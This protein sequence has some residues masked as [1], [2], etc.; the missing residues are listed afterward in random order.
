ML[1]LALGFFIALENSSHSILN[2]LFVTF[3]TDLVCHGCDELLEKLILFHYFLFSLAPQSLGLPDQLSFLSFPFW[4]RIHFQ[5]DLNC[6][7]D[8][9]IMLTHPQTCLL[10]HYLG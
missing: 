7:I 1:G 4:I 8:A 3:Q 10:L 5:N 6:E 2:S 9:L